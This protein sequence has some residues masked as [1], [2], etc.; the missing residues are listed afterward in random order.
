M[1]LMVINFSL[2]EEFEEALIL[3]NKELTLIDLLDSLFLLFGALGLLSWL[4]LCLCWESFDLF[5]SFA[6]FF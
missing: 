5:L 3:S 4:A 2:A 6:I 1:L